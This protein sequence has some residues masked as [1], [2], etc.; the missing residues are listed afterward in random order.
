MIKLY[1]VSFYQSIELQFPGKK[2]NG[3]TISAEV[4]EGIEMRLHDHVITVSHPDWDVEILVGTSN[5]RYAVVENA[6]K[7]TV[8]ILS[9]DPSGEMQAPK[10]TIKKPRAKKKNV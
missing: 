5:M 7:N 10:K 3:N 4:Y 9:I 2:I 1:K 6:A 8:K